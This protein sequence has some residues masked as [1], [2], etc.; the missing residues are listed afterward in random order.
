MRVGIISVVDSTKGLWRDVET[1]I[2]MLRHE[3][4]RHHGKRVD[5]IRVFCMDHVLIAKNPLDGAMLKGATI[6]EEG[7]TVGEFV[8]SVDVVVSCEIFAFGAFDVALKENKRCIYVPNLD[9]AA[10]GGNKEA[11]V[12]ALRTRPWLDV[13]AKQISIQKALVTVGIEARYVPWSI[14]D[15]VVRDR[16]PRDKGVVRFFLNAGNGGY[17]GRRGV[18]LAL[19]A[20]AKAREQFPQLRLT[21]KTIKPVSEYAPLVQH[22]LEGV[23]VIEGFSDRH[24][25]NELMDGADAV[26]HVSRWE[27]F[28]IPMLEALHAGVPVIATDGWPVGDMIEHGH[29]GLLVNAEHKGQR[30]MTPHWEVSVDDLAYQM[31]QMADFELRERMTC[32][33][34]GELAARQ[35]AFLLKGRASILGESNPRVTVV[36]SPLN[37]PS[38]RSEVYVG[39]AFENH[40][41]EVERI[42]WNRH[43]GKNLGVDCDFVLMSKPPPE[44]AKNAKLTARLSVLWHFDS[45]E[46]ISDWFAQVQPHTDVCFVPYMPAKDTSV[47]LYPGPRSTGDR[48]PGKR[49]IKRPSVEQTNDV[50]FIG[51]RHRERAAIL[52]HIGAHTKLTCFGPGMDRGKVWDSKADAAYMSGKVALSISRYKGRYKILGYTSNRLFHAS[53]VGALVVAEHFPGLDDIYPDGIVSFKSGDEAVEV[54]KHALGDDD[55]RRSMAKKAEKYTW[56]HHTW[57]D[58]VLTILNELVERFGA[59]P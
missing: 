48:G 2:W 26:L 15:P 27:G 23:D 28:G 49:P 18:D 5:E 59:T 52:G 4:V 6:V 9:W 8:E 35:H 58:R 33:Q 29:N 51:G 45:P 3:P 32:P 13:W 21:L 31:V 46:Y 25:L 7:T 41:Y 47:T 39:D 12:M 43:D 30:N 38:R 16:E 44:F 37:I 54:I 56:R 11:W 55:Y 50:V 42:E 1:L 19:Q 36:S 14:P 53:A 24:I 20:F 40:G 22:L 57:D 34:P 17:Q 10:I